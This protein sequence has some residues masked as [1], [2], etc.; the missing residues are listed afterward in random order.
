MDNNQQ[1]ADQPA[2][3]PDLSTAIG[4]TTVSP[5]T[6]NLGVNEPGRMGSA[7]SP[8]SGSDVSMTDGPKAGGPIVTTE[9]GSVENA[10][11]P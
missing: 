4:G 10:T 8:L 11:K 6:T 5:G 9:Q 2:S 1:T 7:P 3:K